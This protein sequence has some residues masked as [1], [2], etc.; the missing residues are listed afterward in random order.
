[1][2]TMTHEN[3]EYKKLEMSGSTIHCECGEEIVAFNE[4]MVIEDLLNNFNGEYIFEKKGDVICGNCGS[5]LSYEV[6]F[7]LDV[8]ISGS[9]ANVEM[10]RIV[11]VPI[12]DEGKKENINKFYEG[13]YMNLKDGS[14]ISEGML[15]DVKDNHLVKV[16]NG[17]M[18]KQQL[19]F[20]LN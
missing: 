6:D 14:Y 11:Y 2:T 1:M 3:S 15:Y 4:E 8:S 12:D 10:T 5:T 17:S 16:Y 7:D 19:S 20:Q 9:S 13:D 18:D